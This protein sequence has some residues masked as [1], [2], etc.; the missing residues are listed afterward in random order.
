MTTAP[1]GPRFGFDDLDH[2]E[3]SLEALAH[4]DELEPELLS[5]LEAHPHH[6]PRLETLRA[7]ERWLREGGLRSDGTSGRVF[8]SS[9]LQPL[10]DPCPSSEDLYDFGRGPGFAQLDPE[11]RARIER[12]VQAC[13]ECQGLVTTLSAPPPVPLDFDPLD[14]ER[15]P[16]RPAPEWTE[17]RADERS[18][19]QPGL[20]PAAIPSVHVHPTRQAVP[21]GLP[22][23]LPSVEE[24]AGETSAPSHAAPL[25]SIAA[26]RTR[27]STRPWLRFAAAASL[28]LVAGAALVATLGR[29]DGRGPLAGPLLRGRSLET[30]LAPRGAVLAPSAGLV[31]R[32]PALAGGT[33]FE[34]AP[35]PDAEAYRVELAKSGADPFARG[36]FV[37][38]A[39]SAS[40]LVT[41]TAAL[42]PGRYTW[43]A[44]ATVHGL[45]THL[46]SRDF[47]VVEA[48][49]FADSLATLDA[50]SDPAERLLRALELLDRAGFTADAR[51]LARTLPTGATRDRWLAPVPVR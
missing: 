28:L 14:V 11:H 24:I 41:L 40:P 30:L 31:E 16:E 32:F 36:A 22:G 44:W 8:A 48:R 12:H 33:V 25:P 9:R 35:V 26:A 46:G 23:L 27:R 13:D 10:L 50:V 43:D 2:P 19:A 51:A 3:R 45:E 49:E 34:L 1:Q 7:A 37:A 20:R 21:G 17:T 6:G 29:D 15:S 4:W 39:T 38:D 5:A 47:E 18:D 42:E